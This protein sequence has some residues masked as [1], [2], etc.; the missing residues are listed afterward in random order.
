MRVHLIVDTGGER[1]RREGM[2]C[3]SENSKIFVNQV[4]FFFLQFVSIGVLYYIKGVFVHL[5]SEREKE[6][7]VRS[8]V[9]K[10]L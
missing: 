4:F 9:S 5:I 6:N 10:S 1:G 3:E 7:C 2:G 8:L